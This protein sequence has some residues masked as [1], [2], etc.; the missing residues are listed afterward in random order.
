MKSFFHIVDI[1]F[2]KSIHI[3]SMMSFYISKL[4][5]TIFKLL[6]LIFKIKFGSPQAMAMHNRYDPY[7]RL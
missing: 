7:I 1:C 4:I 3:L 5:F 6:I 2:V